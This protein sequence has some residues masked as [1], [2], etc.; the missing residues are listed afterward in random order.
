MLDISRNDRLELASL[1]VE[2]KDLL[3]FISDKYKNWHPEKCILFLDELFKDKEYNKLVA[4]LITIK[5]QRIRSN[6]L[7]SLDKLMVDGDVDII[8]SLD[9]LLQVVI[10]FSNVDDESDASNRII[11]EYSDGK[12]EKF[13][14]EIPQ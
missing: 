11:I 7:K 13:K 9:K 5:L 4:S 1:D 10:R 3:K 6:L 12:E 14:R 2:G 8:K